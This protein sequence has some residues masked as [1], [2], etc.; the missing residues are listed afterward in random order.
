[1]VVAPV[2]VFAP[3][4]VKVP[5][6]VFVRPLP[7]PLIT[8]LIVVLFEP[9]TVRFVFVNTLIALPLKSRLPPATIPALKVSPRALVKLSVAKLKVC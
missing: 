4:K 2:Y 5:V 3:T 7:V 8:L 6:L 1:M 9:V